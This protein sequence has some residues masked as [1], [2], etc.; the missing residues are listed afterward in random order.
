MEFDAFGT[1]KHE[2]GKSLSKIFFLLHLSAHWGDLI[3]QIKKSLSYTLEGKFLNI[4]KSMYFLIK[5]CVKIDQS[6]LTD[7][8]SWFKSSFV[9]FVYE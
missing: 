3:E 2:E 4:I 8:F 7:L 5:S 6:T 9:F 1:T